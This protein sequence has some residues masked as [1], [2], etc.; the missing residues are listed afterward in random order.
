MRVAAR[1]EYLENVDRPTCPVTVTGDRAI[2]QAVS[3]RLPTAEARVRAQVN[4]YGICG[5]QS[6]TGTG[7]SPSPSDFRCQYHST[8]TPYSLM[9]HLGQ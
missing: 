6:G 3:H 4:P 9:Y 7:L 8:T 1:D 5:E 2:S